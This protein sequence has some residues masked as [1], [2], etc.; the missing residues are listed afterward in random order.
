MSQSPTTRIL[1][2]HDDRYVIS[3]EN[4]VS[5]WRPLAAQG[6]PIYSQELI[7]RAALKQQIDFE[8]DEN[9]VPGSF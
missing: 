7:L 2:G 3:H 8:S 4:A 6:F 1:K 9:K 5:I